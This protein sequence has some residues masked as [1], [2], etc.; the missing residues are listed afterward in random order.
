M[1]ERKQQDE[2][3]V[4]NGIKQGNGHRGVL[5][6]PRGHSLTPRFTPFNRLRTEFDRLFDDFFHG[7]QNWGG[8][9][10]FGAGV[11]LQERDDAVVVRADA[12][13]FEPSDFDVEIRG[14]N[15]VL[16]ACQSAET[17][18]EEGFQWQQRELYRS[19]P[20]PAGVDADKIDAHYRNG[21]LTITLPKTEQAKGKKIEIKS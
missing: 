15:L 17:S 9:P 19:V 5:A 16:C 14:D 11:D 18:Q 13:G 20:L 6:A 8:E 21:V 2:K 1:A 7:W 3:S 10:E 12:P 4:K